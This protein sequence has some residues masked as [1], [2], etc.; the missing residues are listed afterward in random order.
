MLTTINLGVHFLL[1]LAAIGAVAYWGF[2]I[3]SG[4]LARA[5]LGMLLPLILAA[6][7]GI[8][9]VPNDPGPA[10]VAV[11]GWLRLLIEWGIFA[12]AA[13]SL[14]AAGKQN[15]AWAFAILAVTNYAL[16]YERFGRLISS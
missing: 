10:L 9:R 5:A 13:W 3:G 12:L 7:W 8:F 16:M 6:V 14:V 15:L 4:W 11:P 1:E 2:K